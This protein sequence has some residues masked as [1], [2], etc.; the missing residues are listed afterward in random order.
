[1]LESRPNYGIDSCE[2]QRHGRP[3][4]EVTVI[5]PTRIDELSSIV[6]LGLTFSHRTAGPRRVEP[7]ALRETARGEELMPRHSQHQPTLRAK[8]ILLLPAGTS[9]EAFPTGLDSAS[10]A[11]D[12]VGGRRTRGRGRPAGTETDYVNCQNEEA[13]NLTT[14]TP[15]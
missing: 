15:R 14:A 3:R 10:S 7:C 13:R 1:M 6:T 5:P 12:R 9:E 11:G 2:F 4:R 8:A